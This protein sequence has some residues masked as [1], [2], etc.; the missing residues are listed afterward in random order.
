MPYLSE[1]EW[2]TLP[3]QEKAQYNL[4]NNNVEVLVA[5]IQ[6]CNSKHGMLVLDE[7]DVMLG[8][9]ARAAYKQS[10]NIPSSSFSKDGEVRLPLT[11]LTSTRKT[12]F[13][14]VQDEIND[15][16]RTGLVIKHWNTLDVT[17]ACPAKR[18]R[19]DLPHLPI[20][21]SDENLS[22]LG[23]ADYNNIPLKEQE[24]YVA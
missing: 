18:H 24:K 8:D 9:E 17:Q 22:A 7:I 23:E 1:E 10:V 21:R 6:S 19:P 20:Y 5:T 14:L 15:A 13:G 2:K 3:E 12:S 11:V 4:V 16:K